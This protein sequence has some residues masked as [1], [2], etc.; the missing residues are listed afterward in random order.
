[1]E[2]KLQK[3]EEKDTEKYGE[4][5]TIFER[6]GIVSYRILQTQNEQI[7]LCAKIDAMETNSYEFYGKI[8]S[9]HFEP[10]LARI[11]QLEKCRQKQNAHFDQ[12][13]TFQK[14]QSKKLAKMESEIGVQ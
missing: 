4:L 7:K 1:M 10:I 14:K 5:N 8:C 13:N 12:L 2:K 3:D 11:G 6:I 9:E